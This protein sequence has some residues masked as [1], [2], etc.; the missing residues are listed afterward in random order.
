MKPETFTAT[1]KLYKQE[2]QVAHERIRSL[3]EKISELTTMINDVQR[4]DYIK[5]RLMQ[6]GGHDRAFRYIVSDLRYKDATGSC[7]SGLCQCGRLAR[8][9][10]LCATVTNNILII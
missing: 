2:L 7:T 9:R 3:L 5:Y 8:C 1:L 6:I 4:V 10:R